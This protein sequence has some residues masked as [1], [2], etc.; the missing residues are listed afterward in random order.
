MS[1]ENVETVRRAWSALDR[2][3]LDAAFT[4]AAPDAEFD[5]RRAL[6]ID[7]GVYTLDEFKRLTRSFINTWRSLRCEADE[8][9]DARER[10]VLVFTN[11]L[12]GRDGITVEAHGFGVWT[13]R[14]G[15]IVRVCLYQDRAEALEAAGPRE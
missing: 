9:I 10:V 7:R 2:G 3:D 8:L 4:D 6:G 15:R 5:Q 14:E 1:Q 12:T 11:R 13:F